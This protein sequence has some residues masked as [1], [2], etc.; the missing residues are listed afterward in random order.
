MYADLVVAQNCILCQMEGYFLQ[1]N[2]FFIKNT[3]L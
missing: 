3:V 1:G 2:I